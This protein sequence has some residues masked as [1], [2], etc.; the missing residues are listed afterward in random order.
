MRRA[1]LLLLALALGCE[2][3]DDSIAALLDLPADAPRPRLPEGAVLSAETIELGRHLFY[4]VRLSG[5]GTVACSS[6]HRQERGFADDVAVSV[7]ADGQA[8][9]LNA[10]G[11]AN[12][13][14]RMPLTWAHASIGEL[15]A[16]L[17]LPMYGADPL[18]MGMAG[19]EAEIRARLAG[20][21][22]YP[23]LFAAAFADQADPI[24]LEHARLAL[25]SFV[26]SLVSFR[27][28]FDDYLGGDRGALS[29]AA[30]RG[31]ELFFSQRLGCGGCHSG[32]LL[33]AATITEASGALPA[34]AYH[35][36]GLYDVDGAGGYPGPA[37][38]LIA[39]TG[40]PRDMGRFRVPS[41]RNVSV[42]APY[43][44]DGSVATLEEVLAIYERGGRAIASG[45]W[46]GDGKNSPLR[47]DRLRSFELSD[48][49]RADVLAFLEALTDRRFLEDPRLGDPWA[50]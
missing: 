31:S 24:T 44:H 41:L 19:A 7:G 43:M 20:D 48:G 37:P 15:E 29:D 40:I 34:E 25:A 3:D 8:G 39:E 42:T 30:R 35:N 47:S 11:L 26:R 16:Q 32:L 1:G 45:P 17:L 38:G 23:A 2:V 36:I 18:E 21:A 46:A 22:A 50:M 13:A 14:Y 33:S 5:P 12:A 49:E 28:P 10:P 6:C 27:S 9:V 4:D